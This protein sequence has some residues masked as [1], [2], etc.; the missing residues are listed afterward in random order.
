MTCA[1]GDSTE[2]CPDGVSMCEYRTP[3]TGGASPT[4]DGDTVAEGCTQRDEVRSQCLED[5]VD[6]K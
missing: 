2:T 4:K 1:K 6:G 5:V 3:Y